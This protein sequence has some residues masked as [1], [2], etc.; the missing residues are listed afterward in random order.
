M[1]DSHY[2]RFSF[3]EG[4]L[5]KLQIMNVILVDIFGENP[6]FP[7]NN[8]S[9][10]ITKVV[11]HTKFL[12]YG[13]LVFLIWRILWYILKLSKLFAVLIC[14]STL[15]CWCWSFPV[16]SGHNSPRGRVPGVPCG[17]ESSA[18]S[19]GPVDHLSCW[20]EEAV[21]WMLLLFWGYWKKI[22]VLG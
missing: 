7:T 19:W 4:K 2:L 16:L 20:R 3:H 10:W 17:R 22:S 6:I 21:W 9:V 8:C 15:I 11:C 18:G 12:Y 13:S 1:L 5:I 14:Y